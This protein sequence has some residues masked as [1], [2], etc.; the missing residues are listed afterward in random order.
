MLTTH[1][2]TINCTDDV[3]LSGLLYRSKVAP[4]AAVMIAP[5]TGIK[6]GFYARFAQFLAEQNIAVLT[7]DNRGIGASPK[8]HKI[9]GETLLQDW[10]Q[11]DMPATLAWLQQQ[12]P[13][14]P[15]HLIGHSAGGQLAGLMANATELTTLITYGSSSG[16][17]RNF[18]GNYK[19]QAWFYM[20]VFIPVTN[21][22]FGRTQSHWMGMGEPLP[23][24]VGAQWRRWC[25]GQGYAKTEFGTHIKQHYYDQLTQPALWIRATDDEI[26]PQANMDDILSVYKNL[27][28]TNKII[29][30]QEHG[31]RHLG[32]MSYFSR[33]GLPLWSEIV[34]WIK[35]HS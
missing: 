13:A 14:L 7:F 19:Y 20:N 11:K 4:I 23:K 6:Q 31:L 25:N 22:L 34:T 8:D 32:H 35:Q 1:A 16:C 21:A 24:G 2:V 33:Q 18:T 3:Q 26:S 30:P 5:A 9:M 29:H 10:G 28:V 12:F 27:N 15:T 17:L